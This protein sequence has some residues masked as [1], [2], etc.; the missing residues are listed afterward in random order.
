MRE[1]LT[2][3]E[4]RGADVPEARENGPYVI[5]SALRT[6][7]VLRSFAEPPYRFGLAD[8]MAKLGL[9]KNQA[10][11]SLKTLEA[12]GF[13]TATAD[14]RFTLGPAAAELKLAATRSAGASL[15]EVA[16]PLMDRLSEETG[17]TVHLFM[18]TADRALCVDKRDSTQSVRLVSVLGRSF[19]L[20]AG[21][22]PKAIL[23][24]LPERERRAVLEALDGL[25]RYTDK[26][27]ID[28]ARLE[29][30]LEEI[31][32]KGYAVSDEDFDSAARGVG[33]AVFGEDGEVVGGISVGGPSYRVGHGELARFAQLVR[34]AAEE[35]SRRLALAGKL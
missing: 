1:A 15:M 19:P 34:A 9:E 33:A 18:R 32:V 21:A 23:A 25:P 30:L 2:I 8:V 10:Y 16:A 17:E 26:T 14:A 35:I 3:R 12:A 31:R 22:V 27:V 5:A 24:H 20:H 4:E 7:Q 6:L 29:A 11:R 13:L 28:R